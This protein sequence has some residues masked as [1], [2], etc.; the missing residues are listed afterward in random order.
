[1]GRAVK[2]KDTIMWCFV[3]MA[4]GARESGAGF[5]GSGRVDGASKS[6]DVK[7]RNV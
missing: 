6:I 4:G 5:T 2:E 1:V 7:S 3:F